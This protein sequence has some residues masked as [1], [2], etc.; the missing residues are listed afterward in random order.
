M[1]RSGGIIGSAIIATI[2]SFFALLFGM[3]IGWAVLRL[4]P[5]ALAQ[6]GNIPAPPSALMAILLIEAGVFLGLGV[7]G[8]ISTIGLVRLKNWARISF[9]VFGG[10]L[11]VF[12]LFG[13][14]GM[15]V[16]ILFAPPLAPPQ[17]QMPPG[18]M[19]IALAV[20]LVFE[21]LLL[22]IGVWWLIYFSR[23]RTKELFLGEAGAAVPRQGPLSITVI[24]WVLIVTGSLTLV[25]VPFGVPA[26]VFSFVLK[27]WAARLVF[28]LFAIVCLAAGIGILRWRPQAHLL[29]LGFYA[30]CLLNGLSF[31]IPGGMRRAIAAMQ[32]LV[33]QAPSQQAFLTPSFLGASV[34]LGLL[35]TCVPLYFL[36]T[37]RQSFLDACHSVL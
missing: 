25:Y 14:L 10:V 24:A 30:F 33:P 16:V 20:S 11:A 27:G 5:Q 17:A 15:V 36:V 1:K 6:T 37:R 9:L 18:L 21:L 3:V 35:I 29:A 22:A 19:M 8:I 4:N 26:F 7:F 12:S 31:F 34:F 28:S 13:A 23:R 2:G 32:E